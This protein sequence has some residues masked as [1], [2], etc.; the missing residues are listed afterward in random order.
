MG[1]ESS[2]YSLDRGIKPGTYRIVHAKTSKALQI[3]DENKQKLVIWD[4]QNLQ[5][6]DEPTMG[7]DHVRVFLV[8]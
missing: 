5:H 1:Q 8:L 3:R 4:R 7:N 2:T 6:S